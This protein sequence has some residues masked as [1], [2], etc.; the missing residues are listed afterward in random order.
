M[1]PS[2]SRKIASCG[3]SLVDRLVAAETAIGAAQQASGHAVADHNDA[4]FG[5]GR[6]LGKPVGDAGE[7]V[8]VGLTAGGV[9]EPLA[10][11]EE[12]RMI[13]GDVGAQ[14]ALPFAAADLDQ[15]LVQFDRQAKAPRD[16]AG[17]RLRPAGG[18]GDQPPV[19]RGSRS[20]RLPIRSAMA[21][22]W[23]TPSGVR[24]DSMRPCMR[25]SRFHSVSPWRVR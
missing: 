3:T 18:A 10:G 9:E 19:R 24:A 16:R 23:R 22:A 14:A 21:A 6:L 17:R 11:G 2:T 25:P 5:L 20:T 12:L 4:T 7:D 15:A 1:F 13:E 8:V